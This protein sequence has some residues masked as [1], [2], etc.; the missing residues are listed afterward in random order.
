MRSGGQDSAQAPRRDLVSAKRFCLVPPS[1]DLKEFSMHT[2]DDHS[3][4]HLSRSQIYDFDK[5]RS[6]EWLAIR[7]KRDAR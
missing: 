6:I 4:S 3:H 1:W 5:Y 7:Y 2:C